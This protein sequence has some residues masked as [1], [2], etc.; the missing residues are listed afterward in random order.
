MTIKPLTQEK[1][2]RTEKEHIKIT[3]SRV[4]TTYKLNSQKYKR[5]VSG[6][7]ESKFQSSP[8]PISSSVNS[9]MV[10][11]LAGCAVR[12][13]KPFLKKIGRNCKKKTS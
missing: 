10:W 6:H 1:I 5:N 12:K 4:L 11:S 13:C 7:K 9:Q 8:F 3:Q 2:K